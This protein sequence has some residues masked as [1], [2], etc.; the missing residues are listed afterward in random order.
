MA[1]INK[2]I[3]PLMYLEYISSGGSPLEKVVGENFLTYKG[4]QQR[5][6]TDF[7]GWSKI[8]VTVAE[9]NGNLDKA[10]K[11]LETDYTL[12]KMVA[13]Y[14]KLKYWDKCRLDEVQAQHTA[15]EIFVAAV[16]YHPTNAIKMAQSVIGVVTDGIIGKQTLS[17]LN[18][19]SPTLFDKEFDLKEKARNAQIVA[20][21]PAKYQKYKNGWDGRADY[22]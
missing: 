17:A 6:D 13:E 12:Q 8:N 14:Y 4:L 2:S 18:A 5:D 9:C 3:P 7:V 10:S 1:D 20:I 16:L 19:Y 22:V 21:N 11:L 15:D